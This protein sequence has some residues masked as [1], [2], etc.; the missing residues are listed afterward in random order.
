MGETDY[1]NQRA[2]LFADNNSKESYN[3]LTLLTT[4]PLEESN[5]RWFN[6]ANGLFLVKIC[7]YQ[8]KVVPLHG[9]LGQ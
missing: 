9:E 1:T 8:I 5:M 7:T 4:N 3:T 6:S 2:E